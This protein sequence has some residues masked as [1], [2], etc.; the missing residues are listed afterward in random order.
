MIGLSRRASWHR[1]HDYVEI[2]GIK[3]ATCNI[4]ANTPFESGLYFQWGDTQGY[5]SEQV[6]SDTGKKYFGWADY[7]YNDGTASPTASNMTKYNATDGKTV[8][9]PEDDA[10]RAHWGKGWRMPTIEEY[11]ALAAAVNASWVTDYQGSGVNGLLCVDKTDSSKVLFFPVSGNLNN[12]TWSYG[13]TRVYYWASTLHA[14]KLNA[15]HLYVTSDTTRFNYY[16]TRRNGLAIR[17]VLDNHPVPYDAE[18]EYI[19]ND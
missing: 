14:T 2:A 10:A 11:Q 12:G 17:P 18:V 4:G 16:S 1:G 19:E 7:K 6:G 13:N 3:W 5:T 15:Y 9:G 8:L